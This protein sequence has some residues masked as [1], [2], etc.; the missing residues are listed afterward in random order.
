MAKIKLKTMHEGPAYYPIIIA[1]GW[2]FSLL[3]IN[4]YQDGIF[5]MRSFIGGMITAA[6]ALFFNRIVFPWIKKI[7]QN[8]KQKRDNLPQDIEETL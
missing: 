1:L 2:F 6:G 5:S 4:I 8:R 7:R 3:N